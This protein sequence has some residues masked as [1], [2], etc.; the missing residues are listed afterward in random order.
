MKL[1]DIV[2]D[3]RKFKLQARYINKRTTVNKQ[4]VAVLGFSAAKQEVSYRI[5]GSGVNYRQAGR[6]TLSITD[7]EAFVDKTFGGW[8][9]EVEKARVAAALAVQ[10]AARQVKVDA[11]YVEALAFE[12]KVDE[13]VATGAITREEVYLLTVT[14][15]SLAFT[16]G[17]AVGKKD[18]Y[19]DGYSDG[20]SAGYEDGYESGD[21]NY[22][23]TI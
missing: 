10:E 8:E 3:G 4:V 15:A 6:Q 2:R 21:S 22:S 1:G 19:D 9:D 17:R 5:Q 14:A 23:L 13:I 16:A 20:H 7:F 18:G 12:A 11:A